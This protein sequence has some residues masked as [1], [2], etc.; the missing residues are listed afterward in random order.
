MLTIGL[1]GVRLRR[2]HRT[3][4]PAKGPDLF[5]REFTA[6]PVPVKF[7]GDIRYLP[8]RG[9][10]SLYLVTVIDLA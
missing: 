7:V 5:G 10:K 4:D 2:R 9:S 8:V 6:T 3:T 1:G